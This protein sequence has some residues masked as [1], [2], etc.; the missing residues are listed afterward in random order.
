MTRSSP[1]ANLERAYAHINAVPQILRAIRDYHLA[2]DQG[3]HV[4]AAAIECARKIEEALGMLWD[5]GAEL[6]SRIQR[7]A[8]HG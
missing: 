2:L 5:P 7:T 1:V 8:D 6:L 4:D 3:T